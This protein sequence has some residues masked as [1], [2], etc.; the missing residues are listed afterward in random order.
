ME[1]EY[2][3]T[4]KE[5]YN[6]RDFEGAVLDFTYAIEAEPNVADFYY[7]RGLSYFHLNKKS[8]ALMDL[9]EAQ[10]LQPNY[11]FRYSSRAYIKDSCGD[12]VGAIEDYKRAIELDPE[13]AVSYN[14]LGLLQ[15]KLGYE[16]ASKK[17]FT[18]AD[19]LAEKSDFLNLISMEDSKKQE[20]ETAVNDEASSNKP[21]LFNT[22]I[23]VFTDK[24]TFHEFVTFV[25]NG[26]K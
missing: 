10:K 12:T 17:N 19:Q 22:I 14:N 3:N 11:P 7:E 9:N 4:G 25:K 23:K 18:I 16:E 26:F 15:E 8:L 24:K 5:K 1:N 2:F 6:N 21:G 20:S 13:D